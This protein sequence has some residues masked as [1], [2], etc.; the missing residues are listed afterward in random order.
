MIND[1]WE[2]GPLLRS[3]RDQERNLNE[4]TIEEAISKTGVNGLGFFQ[5]FILVICS[6]A[7]SSQTL[8]FNFFGLFTHM[9]IIK[10]ELSDGGETIPCEIDDYC[11]NENN[12]FSGYEIDWSQDSNDGTVKNWVTEYSLICDSEWFLDMAVSLYFGGTIMGAFFV[13]WSAEL[14]GRKP[15]LVVSLSSQILAL[16]MMLMARFHKTSLAV[17]LFILGVN[18]SAQSQV[19]TVFL[20]ELTSVQYK[21][22]FANSLQLS[23]HIWTLILIGISYLTKDIMFCLWLTMII[24]IVILLCFIFFACESP[25]FLFAHSKIDQTLEALEY[26]MNFNRV[27]VIHI[28]L[29]REQ[30]RDGILV[31]SLSMSEEIPPPSPFK[32][33]NPL[34]E[35]FSSKKAFIVT[36][37]MSVLW[38]S[39]NFS[40]YGVA[41]N[42]DQLRGSIFTVLLILGISTMIGTLFVVYFGELLPRKWVLGTGNFMF[43]CSFIIYYSIGEYSDIVSEIALL[44]GIFSI[45]IVFTILFL[46]T[47][48]LFPTFIRST[49]FGFVNVIAKSLVFSIPFL[50]RWLGKEIVIIYIFLGLISLVLTFFLEETKGLPLREEWVLPKDQNEK[51]FE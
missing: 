30:V 38:G 18:L 12:T 20:L 50:T 10:C 44:I 25:R 45:T 9:P 23:T 43:V 24:T 31:S 3:S 22:L 7:L 21:S 32:K 42:A 11:E 49:A 36:T 15:V 4:I 14:W 13:N 46:I 8:L 51:F 37:T 28:N 5:I 16:V 35:L 34:Y 47:A 41:V 39:V 33:F 19:C 1:D 40:Y 26:M 17:S 48:E 27:P 29:R 2:N 6:F